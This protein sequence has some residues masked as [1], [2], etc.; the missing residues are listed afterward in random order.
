MGMRTSE[1]T[2]AYQ[3][4]GA[5]ALSLLVVLGV[6]LGLVRYSNGTPEAPTTGTSGAD[7]S[8]SPSLAPDTSPAPI[9]LTW[10]QSL[11]AFFPM[12]KVTDDS[13][14]STEGV[15]PFRAELIQGSAKVDGSNPGPFGPSTVFD[16]S[17]AYAVGGANPAATAIGDL[18]VTKTTG[19]FTVVAWV[20]D[21]GGPS[22]MEFRAGSHVEGGPLTARQYGLYF[23]AFGYGA[24]RR[25]SPHMSTQDGGTPGYPWNV[26]LGASARQVDTGSWHMEVASY[27][28]EKL[29]A[30]I[31]GVPDSYPD[32]SEPEPDPGYSKQRLHIS[33]N[34]YFND[35]GINSS[36]TKKIF[37]IG[38]ALIGE[39]PYTPVNHTK[40]WIGGVAVFNEALSAE[41]IKHIRLA[42]LGPDEPVVDLDFFSTARGQLPAQFLGWKSFETY[43]AKDVSASLDA[44]TAYHLFTPTEDTGHLVRQGGGTEPGLVYFPLTP[45]SAGEVSRVTFDLNSSTPDASPQ[46]LVA[47]FGDQWYGTSEQFWTEKNHTSSSDWS[48]AEPRSVD[49]FAATTKWRVLEFDPKAKRLSLLDQ[50]EVPEGPLTAIG[51]YST[52]SDGIAR[53][54]DVKL[55]R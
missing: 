5:L 30:Y 54:G 38:A 9:K 33:K 17:T 6:V 2:R 27:D 41:E 23:N 18:D 45:F 55:L 43:A 21:E 34:P 16:G 25:V 28:G 49:L 37:T 53:I 32:Y 47:R 13:L 44:A 35:G 48:S 36:P 14:V 15:A 51:F 31:D 42:T 24:S 52:D 19:R 29:V 50:R 3:V 46:H 11:V 22:Q 40:G 39:T 20:K 7:Q 12:N 4:A 26:D 10:P 1:Q 8:P